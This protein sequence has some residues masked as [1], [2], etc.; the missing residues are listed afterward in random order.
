MFL[1]DRLLAYIEKHGLIRFFIILYCACVVYIIFYLIYQ[2]I[3]FFH[4]ITIPYTG[5]QNLIP[6]YQWPAFIVLDTI[7]W[8]LFN[9]ALA[10]LWFLTGIFLIL[11][12]VYA[13]ARL[14]LL[15]WLLIAFFKVFRDCKT[16]GIF[17]LFDRLIIAFFGPFLVAD[18]LRRIILATFD[19]IE[20]FFEETFDVFLPGYKFNADYL[21][22]A[23]DYVTEPMTEEKK[24]KLLELLAS[25]T[26][27]I[28][29]N[30]T[31]EPVEG[32]INLDYMDMLKA[33]QCFK[34]NMITERGDENTIE[35]LRIILSNT[36]AKQECLEETKE[37]LGKGGKHASDAM[38]GQTITN[39]DNLGKTVTY[40][41]QLLV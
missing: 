4:M 8:H 19:F 38:S 1:W 30:I 20:N 40:P 24:G 37:Y 12:A 7:L 28:K 10:T 18:K 3:K 29:I 32:T 13:A 16:Y 11:Y 36:L 25:A 39:I 15:D 9:L 6:L 21:Q 34:A 2:I 14:I 27:Y 23:I 35:R 17:D 22:A 26:P 5:W 41:K 33:N 31:D